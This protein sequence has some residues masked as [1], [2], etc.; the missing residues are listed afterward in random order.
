MQR[1]SNT[2]A[3]EYTLVWIYADKV[4]KDVTLK[5]T[6]VCWSVK[7]TTPSSGCKRFL[8]ASLTCSLPVNMHLWDTFDQLCY[9]E[10]SG[11]AVW[12]ETGSGGSYFQ[13]R[14]RDFLMLD[15][16][17]SMSHL[18]VVFR[19]RKMNACKEVSCLGLRKQS[20]SLCLRLCW[21]YFFFS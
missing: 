18:T 6:C 19:T 10:S 2:E 5:P 13:L 21:V 7:T 8:G 9:F 11:A 4:K 20:P 17:I 16:I 3:S 1:H 12:T 14:G 15:K